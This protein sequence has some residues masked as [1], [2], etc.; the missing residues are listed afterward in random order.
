MVHGLLKLTALCLLQLCMGCGTPVPPV[1]VVCPLPLSLQLDVDTGPYTTADT[2][3]GLILLKNDAAIPVYVP[4]RD[5]LYRLTI[6]DRDGDSVIVNAMPDIARD[7]IILAPQ[8]TYSLPISVTSTRPLSDTDDVTEGRFTR[9]YVRNHRGWHLQ[10]AQLVWGNPDTHQLRYPVLVGKYR[11]FVSFPSLKL[12]T[13]Q[14]I[15]DIPDDPGF[16]SSSV[17][18]LEPGMTEQE[19]N[20][21]LYGRPDRIFASIVGREA[22]GPGDL[23]DGTVYRTWQYNLR[24]KWRLMLYFVHPVDRN[25]PIRHAAMHRQW[26]LHSWE[27][28]FDPPAI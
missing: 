15:V 28:E 22:G 6:I 17:S 9:R 18:A 7:S 5:L 27:M 3:E 26:E 20:G 11:V 25:R 10:K 21:L 8:E 24:R 19:A 12:E 16:P 2:V 13:V 4:V 1:S 14:Q 23:P